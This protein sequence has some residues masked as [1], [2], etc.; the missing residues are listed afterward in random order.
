MSSYFQGPQTLISQWENRLSGVYLCV[1]V[2]GP[3]GVHTEE[4]F[5]LPPDCAAEGCHLVPQYRNILCSFL[6]EERMSVSTCAY[7]LENKQCA[8]TVHNVHGSVGII[9]VLR[10]RDSER[11]KVLST[12]LAEWHQEEMQ[13]WYL[14]SQQ[15]HRG[16]HLCAC[17]CFRFRP[18]VVS[19]PGITAAASSK[20]QTLRNT[21]RWKRRERMGAQKQIHRLCL[22]WNCDN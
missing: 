11:N 7:E 6:K 3:H 10:G 14:G 21:Q 16:S 15:C 13:H 12:D 20:S 17:V 2:V 8:A 4:W 9:R 19:T 5:S 22:W 18:S 1:C